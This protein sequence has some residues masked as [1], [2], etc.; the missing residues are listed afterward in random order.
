MLIVKFYETNIINITKEAELTS[1]PSVAPNNVWSVQ[2][3]PHGES[4]FIWLDVL[5]RCS[6]GKQLLINNGKPSVI[7]V[8][9]EV[10]K[11]GWN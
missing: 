5:K 2:G 1:E 3:V 10:K 6:G 4:C 7:C 9:S 8:Y 11:A